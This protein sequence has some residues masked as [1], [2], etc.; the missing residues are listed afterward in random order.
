MLRR[1]VVIVVAIVGLVHSAGAQVSPGKLSRAHENLEGITQCTTC[2]ERGAQVGTTLCLAC[3]TDIKASID[4]GTGLHARNAGSSCETCHK[5][6]LGVDAAITQFDR[7]TF[8]HPVTGFALTGAHRSLDCER[9]HQAKNVKLEAVRKFS[10]PSGR[11]TLLGLGT[12]CASC[13]ADRHNGTL[14]NDCASCHS[15]DAW[16]PAPGFKHASTKFPLTGKHL[17]VECTKCHE[18]PA[19][20]T[21]PRLFAAKPFEQCTPCHT[22]PHPPGFGAKRTCANCHT[23]EGWKSVAGFDHGVTRFPLVGAH[24]NVACAKCHTQMDRPNADVKVRFAA[25]PTADCTPCHQTPHGPGFTGRTCSSCH[26]PQAWSAVNR[27]QFDHGITRFVLAGAHTTVACE[28]CHARTPTSTFVTAFRTGPKPCVE[29]HR[30]PHG[31]IFVQRYGADCARCHTDREFV[32]SLFTLAMHDASAFALTGAHQAVPCAPCHR[33]PATKKLELHKSSFKCA[34]CH[35]DKHKGQFANQMAL[36]SCA[37][38]HATTTWSMRSFD[39][40]STGFALSGRH[41]VVACGQCHKPDARGVVQY[42]GVPQAC[43]SCHADVHRGQFTKNGSVECQACHTPQAWTSLLFDHERQST[44]SLTGAHR[45]VAC[46]G[47]HRP[48]RAG[49]TVF[50]RFKPLAAGC[51]TCH[52]GKI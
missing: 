11:V 49:D 50:V 34:A 52:Q 30:D 1:S 13:H 23:T 36:K 19:S 21:A 44:F 4:R 35:E 16:K 39:H 24:A 28:K 18:A 3:H 20:P 25:K 17:Q 42:S 45:R 31:G 9:C 10:R 32:P 12:T 48:E 14:S 15:S 41:A 38:C 47:C 26:A 27:S 43:A 22:S 6:H 8:N 51:E 37:Q 29:C 2:H 5:E 40:A 33:A 46:A 7:S